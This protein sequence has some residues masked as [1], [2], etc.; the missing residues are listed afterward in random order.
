MQVR[1]T[2][3]QKIKIANGEDVF[4]IIS[5]I[6]KREG[7]LG[8]QK[9]HFYVIG[10]DSAYF[11]LFIE[12]ISMGSNTEAVV[13]PIPVFHQ[14]AAK[15]APYIIL[16]HNHPSGNLKASEADI[17]LTRRLVEGSKLLDII[18]L[19]HLIVSETGFASMKDAK[20]I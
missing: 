5:A 19:D 11:I 10:L 1:L 14:A 18:I 17:L 15:N 4:K 12:L 9:E 6:I 2:K 8:K 13:K 16:A 20:I 7:R 3:E